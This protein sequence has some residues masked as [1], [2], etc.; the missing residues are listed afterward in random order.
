MMEKS[1]GFDISGSQDID[2]VTVRYLPAQ[3]ESAITTI[4]EALMFL[5]S[6]ELPDSHVVIAILT[7]HQEYYPGRFLILDALSFRP[8]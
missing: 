4:D 3:E 7:C 5:R 1:F 2:G 8:G 6:M